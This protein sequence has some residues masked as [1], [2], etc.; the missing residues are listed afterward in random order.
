MSLKFIF[1]I[2]LDCDAKIAIFLYMMYSNA[3]FCSFHSSLWISHFVVP[4]TFSSFYAMM[5]F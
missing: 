1:S 5:A 2:V 3:S 4:T